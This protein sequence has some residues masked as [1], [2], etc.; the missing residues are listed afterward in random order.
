MD[1]KYRFKYRDTGSISE[2]DAMDVPEMIRNS[3]DWECLDDVTRIMLGDAADVVMRNTSR[4]AV[5]K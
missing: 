3:H 5:K 4:E 2:F 1:K